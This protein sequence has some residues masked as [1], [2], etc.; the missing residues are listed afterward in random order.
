VW[1]S[2]GRLHAE[3]SDNGDGFD[4]AAAEQ[5]M[6][7]RAELIHGHLDI[8]SDPATGTT[9]RVEAPLH[10]VHNGGVELVR[11]LLVEDHIAVL[12]AIAAMFER[13]P[14]FTQGVDATRDLVAGGADGLDSVVL[15]GRGGPSRGSACRSRP[16][17]PRAGRLITARRPP[18]R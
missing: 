8:P 18:R 16:G 14:D 10:A 3:V 5:G 13:E 12:Q 9:V 4:P 1:S 6:R 15:S 2:G 11:V 17:R 7:E